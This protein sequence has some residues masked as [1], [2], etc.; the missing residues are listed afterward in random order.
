MSRDSWTIF[1]S[2]ADGL[3]L[4]GI[5]SV[6]PIQNKSIA[7][8]EGIAGCFLDSNIY[9]RKEPLPTM[10]FCQL[11]ISGSGHVLFL[12]EICNRETAVGKS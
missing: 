8:D 5:V 2:T 1:P 3:I 7:C 10:W 4:S 11:V 12:W 9:N 6:L